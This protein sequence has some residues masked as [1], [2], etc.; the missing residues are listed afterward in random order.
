MKEVW[1]K[2]PD[3]EE[4]YEISNSGEVRSIKRL[5]VQ[6]L[7]MSM[8][9]P[10]ILSPTLDRN[11]YYRV[12]LSCNGKSVT[13]KVHRLV[14]MA[15]LPNPHKFPCINHKDENKQNNYICVNADGSVDF[16]KS[17]LEWCTYKYNTNYGNAISRKVESTN[18]AVYSYNIE[19]GEIINYKSIK[20]ASTL[21][22]LDPSAITAVCKKKKR[23]TH[24]YIFRYK[25]E[26]L[27]DEEIE[28]AKSFYKP[29]IMLSMNGEFL[30]EFPSISDAA[31][32][33]N[34]PL[35]CISL[36]CNGKQKYSKGHKW[37]F[38]K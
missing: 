5:R 17:N 24:G 3:F 37:I 14:A 10:R 25:M 19:N 36:C 11:G 21:L 12:H 8:L 30:K 1:K 4:Y 33:T 22:R 20:E 23:T 16:E 18:K 27:A 26:C 32:E 2:I 28:L 34:T 15:F 9:A 13:K 29:V 38:K 35:S 31:T 6:G 7:G